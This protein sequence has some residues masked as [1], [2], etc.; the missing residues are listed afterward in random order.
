[1]LVTVTYAVKKGDTVESIEQWFDAHGY[2]A[3]FEANLQV[4]EDNADLLVPGAI[5]TIS[6]GVMT[7]HSPL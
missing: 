5:V 1:V 2:A 6:N 7:I 4:I 3:Q